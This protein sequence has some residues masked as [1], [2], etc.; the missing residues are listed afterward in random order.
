VRLNKHYGYRDMCCQLSSIRLILVNTRSCYKYLEAK[1]SKS[2]SHEVCRTA[3]VT[4]GNI[5]KYRSSLVCLR[6][7]LERTETTVI[8][9]ST[10]FGQESVGD[11]YVLIR[12]AAE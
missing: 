10:S 1:V 8:P 11:G 4:I 2:R 3:Y 9:E 7:L 6:S 5:E 12:L